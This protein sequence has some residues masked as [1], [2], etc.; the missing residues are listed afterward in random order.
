METSDDDELSK[1]G[2]EGESA[3]EEVIERRCSKYSAGLNE[4]L[5]E[6]SLVETLNSIQ[7]PWQMNFS[8]MQKHD[9]RNQDDNPNAHTIEVLQKM[10]D[11]YERT[12][13]KWRVIA[14]RKAIAC[15]KKQKNKITTKVEALALP[16]I[17]ARLAAKIE[18]IVLTN[19][20]RRLDNATSDNPEDKV[21][22]LFLGIY[23]VGLVQ[24]QKWISQGYKTL[25]S[26]SESASLTPNQL[27]GVD[28]YKDFQLRIPRPEVSTH[29]MFIR[30]QVEA[31]SPDIEV[32]VGGSYR[33]GAPDCGDIDF[34]LT[35]PTLSITALRSLFMNSLLPRLFALRYLRAQLTEIDPVTGTKWHGA[36]CLPRAKV[37]TWRRVDFLLV[38]WEEMGAALIYFT[39]NDLFNRSIRLL[40]LKKGMRLNQHGLFKDVMRAPGRQKITEGKL[41]EAKSEKL[42]FQHLGVPWRPPEHRIC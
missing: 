13:D 36:A 15:L 21:L 41:M 17:G 18:E 2:T 16:S 34:L 33:R 29:A 42:I 6:A 14:Y 3:S 37:Q 8:C 10:A 39:G 5:N 1:L 22:Q 32:T 20:L 40:A 28:H 9:G 23:G 24:A 7:K 11:Y 26:L 27:I 12:K 19:R 4:H 35:S 31:V 38:P 30:A 25:A